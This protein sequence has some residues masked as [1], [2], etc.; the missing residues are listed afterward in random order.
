MKQ[1]VRRLKRPW[2]RCGIF[3]FGL[4]E[5]W[6]RT[7]Q[8]HQAEKVKVQLLTPGQAL[9]DSC[10]QRRGRTLAPCPE[11]PPR[12]KS[13]L[14]ERPRSSCPSAEL[15]SVGKG[16]HSGT[17]EGPSTSLTLQTGFQPSPGRVYKEGGQ[18]RAKLSIASP[19]DPLPSVQRCRNSSNLGDLCQLKTASATCSFLSKG[20]EASN[21][22]RPPPCPPAA[23]CR[24]QNNQ[25]PFPCTKVGAVPQVLAKIEI[26]DKKHLRVAEEREARLF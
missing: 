3:I 20:R 8:G 19:R 24:A 21:T 16:G 13:S 5:R 2:R 4:A 1:K 15:P 23:P 12:S 7:P 9:T 11:R 6:L 14:R 18:D 10:C 17:L 26:P 25:P 22:C